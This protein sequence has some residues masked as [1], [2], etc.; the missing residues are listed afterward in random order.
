MTRPAMSLP[1]PIQEAE[2]SEALHRGLVKVES[3]NSML[4]G[5]AS[6]MSTMSGVDSG[7]RA[8][9]RGL[10]CLAAA[11][12]NRGRWGQQSDACVLWRGGKELTA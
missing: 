9:G 8:R 4:S 3:T 7:L 10:S 6:S 2:R 11:V 1:K 12:P 5:E